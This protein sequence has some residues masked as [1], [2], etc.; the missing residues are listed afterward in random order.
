MSKSIQSLFHVE[1]S[2]TDADSVILVGRGV[3]SPARG[4]PRK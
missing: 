4:K 3:L 2:L 1:Q